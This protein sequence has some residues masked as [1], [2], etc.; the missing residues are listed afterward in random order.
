MTD[1]TSDIIKIAIAGCVCGVLM[2]FTHGEHGIGW[3]AFC[4]WMILQS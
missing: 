3:F 4:V 1:K 2:V